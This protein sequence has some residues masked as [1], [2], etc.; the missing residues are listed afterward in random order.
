MKLTFLILG[1]LFLGSSFA[2]SAIM[3]DEARVRGSL[4]WTCQ[5]PDKATGWVECHSTKN[6]DALFRLD[7]DHLALQLSLALT[8][9]GCL[10]AAAAVGNRPKPVPGPQQWQQQP[11]QPPQPQQPYGQSR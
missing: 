6:S 3:S 8:G 5:P 4:E 1:F 2:V 10:V 9:V 7:I 11:Q